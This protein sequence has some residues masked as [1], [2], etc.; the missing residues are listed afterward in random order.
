[1]EE[2]SNTIGIRDTLL[3]IRKNRARAG[4]PEQV[5][6][7]TRGGRFKQFRIEFGTARTELAEKGGLSHSAQSK[8]ESG[9]LS[10]TFQTLFRGV[11]GFLVDM[12]RLP[13][14]RGPSVHAKAW[15]PLASRTWP[16]PRDRPLCLPDAGR[17]VGQQAGDPVGRRDQ[18]ELDRIP[19]AHFFTYRRGRPR[20]PE[21]RYRVARRRL[22]PRAAPCRRLRLF[23]QCNAACLHFLVRG[24]RALA[25]D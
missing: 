18:G 22:R 17:R 23:R 16:T 19:R 9:P 15:G 7:A 21:W 20:S 25:L 4:M 13:T 24:G 2:S 10:P 6:A 8:F 1:M 14:T 3:L 12:S 11:L 5:T